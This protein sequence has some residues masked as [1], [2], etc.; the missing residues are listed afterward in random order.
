MKRQILLSILLMGTVANFGMRPQKTTSCA[1][2][3]ISA[4]VEQKKS[5]EESN[6][7]ERLLIK[8]AYEGNLGEVKK[9]I[10]QD[11]PL[12]AALSTAAGRGH[13]KIVEALLAAG[14]DVNGK[15]R[16]GETALVNAALFQRYAMVELLLNNKANPN[17]QNRKAQYTPLMW[18]S[19]V[20]NAAIVKLLLDRGADPMLQNKFGRTALMIQESF[21]PIRRNQQIITML[22]KAEREARL[23][24]EF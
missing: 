10:Q 13:A 24:N 11:A 2:T 21:E 23:E 7:L 15:D 9:L 16:D 3:P 20:G 4:E 14:G 6:K 8:A 17:L 19:H 5:Q 22:Q 18:A 1:V 12:N